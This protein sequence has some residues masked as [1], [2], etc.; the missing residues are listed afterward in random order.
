MTEHKVRISE[1][2]LRDRINRALPDGA[3]KPITGLFSSSIRF[4][5][6]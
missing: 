2:M 3:L 6:W 1:K 5:V 4:A